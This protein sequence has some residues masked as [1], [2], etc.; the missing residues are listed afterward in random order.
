MSDTI[1]NSPRMGSFPFSA[2]QPAIVNMCKQN[3]TDSVHL[4]FRRKRARYGW[5]GARASKNSSP[6][7]SIVEYYHI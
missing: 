5:R 6:Q 7:F 3:R 1:Q 4:L 2:L